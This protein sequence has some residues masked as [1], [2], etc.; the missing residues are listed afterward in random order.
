MTYPQ[1]RENITGVARS[2]DDLLD[3]DDRSLARRRMMI[4]TARALYDAVLVGNPVPKVARMYTRMANPRAGDL[5]LEVSHFSRDEDTEAKGF[6]ILMAQ[7][8]EWAQTDEEWAAVTE[9]GYAGPRTLD[10]AWY[11]QYGPAAT[12]VCRWTNCQ[13]V[14]VPTT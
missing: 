3:L 8:T 7:R 13:F 4:A 14:A 1:P 9:S 10:E 6:G 2:E 5:V 11:V 12:D